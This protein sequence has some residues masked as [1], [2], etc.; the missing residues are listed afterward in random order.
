MPLT[1]CEL[2]L[3]WPPAGGRERPGSIATLPARPQSRACQRLPQHRVPLVVSRNGERSKENEAGKKE[4]RG[5]GEN[6]ISISINCILRT[7]LASSWLF[8]NGRGQS[9]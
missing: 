4:G 8:S 7:S 6:G 3:R 9:R 1:D 5:E 2:D